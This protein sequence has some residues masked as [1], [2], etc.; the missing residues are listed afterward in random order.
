MTSVSRQV[1]DLCVRASKVARGKL[2]Q[3]TERSRKSAWLVERVVCRAVGCLRQLRHF[4]V[5]CSAADMVMLFGQR[6]VAVLLMDKSASIGATDLSDFGPHT[7]NMPVTSWSADRLH[8]VTNTFIAHRLQAKYVCMCTDR[9][10]LL[11]IQR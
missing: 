5:K 1:C 7:Y 4:A 6:R 3:S 9:W 10:G 2:G 8:S 11:S